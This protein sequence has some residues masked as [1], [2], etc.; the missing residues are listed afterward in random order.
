MTVGDAKMKRS[1]LPGQSHF[2]PNNV[3][4]DG[5]RRWLRS[6]AAVLLIGSLIAF[7]H[8]R[9]PWWLFAAFLFVPDF[10]CAGYLQGN[11]VG[12]FLYNVA[13]ATPLPAVLIALGYF[14]RS[15]L[16]EALGLVWIVHIGV[17]RLLGY[18]LKYADS[19]QHTHLGVLGRHRHEASN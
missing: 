4:G 7:S 16:A 11:R 1:V 13:H 14:Q 17:D 8:T 15:P 3:V 9:E 12:A 10:S 19:F 6:E 5:P 2:D 18:G